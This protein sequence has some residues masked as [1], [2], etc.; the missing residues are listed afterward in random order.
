MVADAPVHTAHISMVEQIEALL[1]EEGAGCS[2]VAIKEG[3]N[4]LEPDPKLS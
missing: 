2:P 4:L 1:H 3:M